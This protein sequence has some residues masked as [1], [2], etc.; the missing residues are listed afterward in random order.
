M[1]SIDEHQIKH[2]KNRR[3]Y[4]DSVDILCIILTYLVKLNVK[5]KQKQTQVIT[6]NTYCC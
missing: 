5:K 1:Q 6:V 3:K 4:F 2:A